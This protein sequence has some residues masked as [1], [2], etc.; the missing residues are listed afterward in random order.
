MGFLLSWLQKISASFISSFSLDMRVGPVRN[1]CYLSMHKPS[2]IRLLLRD[3]R[4]NSYVGR[5]ATHH[6]HKLLINPWHREEEPHN[7]HETPGRQTKQ[8][9]QL[10]LPHQDD[11][12]TRRD[13]KQPTNKKETSL[14]G[15]KENSAKPR[16][17]GEKL[18]LRGQNLEPIVFYSSSNHPWIFC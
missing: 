17:T 6:N 15:P 14:S 11:C 16:K 2:S 1:D 3:F 5:K 13:I 9:N 8:S 10:S 18:P 12:N 4:Q 7:N